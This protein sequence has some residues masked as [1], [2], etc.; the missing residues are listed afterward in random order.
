M[1][2]IPDILKKAYWHLS[3]MLLLLWETFLKFYR[4]HTDI[5]AESFCGHE[6]YYKRF[7]GMFMLSWKTF[8]ILHRNITDVSVECFSR[9]EKHSRYVTKSLLTSQW[10]VPVANRNGSDKYNKMFLENNK[11][12]SC[13]YFSE[14]FLYFFSLKY[15]FILSQRENVHIQ[16]DSEKLL[17]INTDS[18]IIWLEMNIFFSFKIE[19]TKQNK[20]F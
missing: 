10:T 4:N 18:A 12:H 20:Q 2:N 8:L 15:S 13:H 19:V 16:I 7:S 17:F 1:R 14:M 11:Q 6:K 9:N 3:R 5:W